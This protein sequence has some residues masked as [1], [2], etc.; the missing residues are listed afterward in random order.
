MSFAFCSKNL[1][2]ELGYVEYTLKN[3]WSPSK[4]IF[5]AVSMIVEGTLADP[6]FDFDDALADMPLMRAWQRL[7]VAIVWVAP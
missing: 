6:T 5:D 2:S 1:Q 3:D 7:H 4:Q